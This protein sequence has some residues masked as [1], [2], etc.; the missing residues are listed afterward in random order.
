MGLSGLLAAIAGDYTQRYIDRI[1][2]YTSDR[3]RTDT[4]TAPVATAAVETPEKTDTYEPTVTPPVDTDTDRKKIDTSTDKTETPT[5]T[6]DTPSAAAQPDE[7][8]YYK[9]TANLD[10][11]LDLRFNLST[12]TQTVQYLADGETEAVELFAAAGF[13]LSA[14]FN[15]KGSETIET[16]MADYTD[17]QNVNLQ[18][19]TQAKSRRIS[20]FKAQ[21]D[22][23]KLNSFMRQAADINRS[24][25]VKVRDNHYKAVNKIAYRYSVDNRFS[26]SFA[27]RFNLQT[28]KL[29]GETPEVQNGY[30]DTTGDLA[31]SGTVEMMAT[32]FDAVESYLAETEEAFTANTE[33]FFRSAASELGFGAEL[34]DYSSEQLT[35]TIENFFDRVEAAVAKLEALYVPAEATP[36]VSAPDVSLY[37]PATYVE[38]VQLAEV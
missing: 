20:K 15:L 2:K 5:E 16:N 19:Q 6:A 24:L 7:I 30:F 8:Y 27:E 4:A 35:G 3:E 10:Y 33:S 34:V 28:E 18:E 21:S 1:N 12:L 32:F 26:F 38:P 37:D 29:T 11:K 31:D 13:G 17:R 25:D 23:F 22:N 9:R 14:D 36:A